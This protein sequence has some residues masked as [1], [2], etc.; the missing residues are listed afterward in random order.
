PQGPRSP[1]VRMLCLNVPGFF[2]ADGI[3]PSLQG[4]PRAAEDAGLRGCGGR[5]PKA[6]P[7]RDKPF[8]KGQ[9]TRVGNSSVLWSTVQHRADAGRRNN[10]RGP[11]VRARRGARPVAGP[12]RR[13]TGD[14][15]ED[16]GPEPHTGDSADG[17]DR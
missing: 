5:A 8:P 15:N 1:K 11:R 13:H 16:V 10:S 17:N 2:D 4:Y 12:A 9:S 3:P 7:G 14:T 6:Y